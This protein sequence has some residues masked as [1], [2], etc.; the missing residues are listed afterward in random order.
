MSPEESKEEA[1]RRAEDAT[2]RVV[3]GLETGIAVEE[4]IALVRL[5]SGEAVDQ[6]FVRSVL[7]KEFRRNAG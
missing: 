5:T 3:T 4:V 6:E 1:T 7:C 2:R